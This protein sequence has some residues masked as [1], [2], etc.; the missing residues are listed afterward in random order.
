MPCNERTLDNMLSKSHYS[1]RS[2]VQGQSNKRQR[3]DQALPIVPG[4]LQ[5]ESHP[6]LATRMTILLDSGASQSI[7]HNNILSGHC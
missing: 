6:T 5:K 2:M 4:L 7:I 3:L 1:I